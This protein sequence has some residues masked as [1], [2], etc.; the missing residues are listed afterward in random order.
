[1]TT[2]TIRLNDVK[3]AIDFDYQPA[4]Q[5]TWLYPGCAEEYEINSVLVGINDIDIVEFLS[6]DAKNDII[7]ALES[8]CLRLAA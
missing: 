7:K 5:G 3:V 1:M 2:R 4:E 6:D 8:E